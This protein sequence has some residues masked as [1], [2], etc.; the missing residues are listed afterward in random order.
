MADYFLFDKMRSLRQRVAIS[1]EDTDTPLPGMISSYFQN[2][3]NAPLSSVIVHNRKY[4][5][6]V[7]GYYDEALS[8]NRALK[9]VRNRIAWRGE[10]AILSLGQYVAVLSKPAGSK[11]AIR[12]A[13]GT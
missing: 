8:V 6:L 1:A 3:N 12:R 13:V 4:R 7:V 2:P 9:I 10:V 5:Y 11:V